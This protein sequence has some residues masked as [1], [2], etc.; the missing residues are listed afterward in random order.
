MKKAVLLIGLYLL[1]FF[2]FAQVNHSNE[3]FKI[4]KANDSLLFN[5]GFN[6]C[7]LSQFEKLVSENFEFYHDQAGITS[8]KAAFILGVKNGLCKLP[9]KPVRELEE[10]SL[11]VFPLQNEGV[12]YGA[13]Q[14]GRHSFYAIEKDKPRRL[15]STAKF[16]HVWLI[17]NG[18]W[19]LSRG[20]SYDHGPGN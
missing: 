10:N 14:T 15:T 1:P 6:N 12:L 11:E 18:V 2:L 13:I 17:E 20:L 8:T 7:D 3:L 4:L 16:T 5:L 19:K 9:Y